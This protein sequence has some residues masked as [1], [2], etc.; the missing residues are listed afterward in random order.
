[1]SAIRYEGDIEAT[2]QGIP[3]QVEILS[4]SPGCG[5]AITGSGFGDAEPPEPE[6]VEFQLR[7]RRGYRAEWLERKMTPGDREA[8]ERL[9]SNSREAVCDPF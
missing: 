2:V 3:C 6:E 8:I 9:I 4:Y 1:M 5:M 7:D